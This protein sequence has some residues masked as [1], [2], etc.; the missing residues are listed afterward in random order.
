MNNSPKSWSIF[1]TLSADRVSLHWSVF[2]NIQYILGQ[3]REEQKT[4]Q[5]IEKIYIDTIFVIFI[6]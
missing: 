3:D 1:V 4:I 2:A 5:K 6:H